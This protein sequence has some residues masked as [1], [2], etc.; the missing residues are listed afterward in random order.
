MASLVRAQDRSCRSGS[1]I[2]GIS[3]WV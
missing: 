3:A 2:F 1:R